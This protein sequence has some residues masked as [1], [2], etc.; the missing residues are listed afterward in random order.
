MRGHFI[1]FEGGEGSGKTSAIELL[2]AYLQEQGYEVMVTR[3]PGGIN[4]A[5]QIRQ[6][7]LNKD[8]V[9]MDQLTEAY[10][11]AASRR[12]HL[13]EKV[14]PALEAGKIVLCDRF[15][16][17]SIVYQGYAR[18]IGMELVEHIN[19]IVVNGYMPHLTLFFDVLPETGL[20]RI[21]ENLRK[22]NRLDLEVK[23]FHQKV[24]DGYHILAKKHERIQI[25][26]GE[27]SLEEVFEQAKDVVEAF[28]NAE[29]V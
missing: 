9:E 17:S 12:Q 26:D 18:E 10:L 13:V 16:D 5:E 14:V 28:L 24:Y 11:F 4:I 27:K 6:V 2:S 1:T 8:N 22:V 21:M 7:I 15:V 25:I 20:K 19:E 3:E 23:E 29:S